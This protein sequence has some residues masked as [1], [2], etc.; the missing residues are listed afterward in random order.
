LSVHSARRRVLES[1]LEAAGG[2]AA[3]ITQRANVRYL[4]GFTGSSG[5]LLIVRSGAATLLTDFRYEEQAQTE[6][7]DGA[8]V[9]VVRGPWMAALPDVLGE[10]VERIAFESDHLTVADHERLIEVLPDVDGVP[11]RDL[12]GTLRRVKDATELEAIERAVLIAER[13][14]ERVLLAIDWRGGP[15]EIQVASALGAELR[16]GGSEVLPFEVIAAAGPRSA[17][18]HA[19]PSDRP[20]ETGDLLLL[21]F[22]ARADGYCS[23]ITRTFVLGP[24][25]P[26][27]ATVH[28]QVLE[29][30]TLARAAVVDG[31]SCRDVD[32]A[33][34]DALARHE[35]DRYFGHSTGHGLGLEVHEGPSLSSRSEDTL[36]LGN[37]VTVEPGVYLP[38]RGGVRIEDDVLVGDRG[39]RTLTNLPRELVQL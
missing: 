3:L 29:A 36:A 21:D 33:A 2:D 7:A 18:P 27:Q 11:V 15:T 9:R 31:A 38:G 8:R 20:I 30:Q 37:V 12:V 10:E 13:A 4:S 1:V 32:A 6:V 22:G 5:A 17:L 23:D 19:S 34:R 25:E 14:L 24:P 39:P 28:A 26:W 16:R 35:V